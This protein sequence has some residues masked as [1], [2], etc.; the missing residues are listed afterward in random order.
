MSKIK[1]GKGFVLIFTITVLSLVTILT[2]QLLRMVNVGS[3]FDRTM[4]N[5][6]RAEM[7]ALGGIS[8]AISQ[9]TV[10]KKKP[11]KNSKKETKDKKKP[12]GKKDKAFTAYLQNLIPNLNRWQ[13][14]ELDEEIDGIDGE[15]KI[16]I[17]SEDGKININEAFD[18][19]KQEFKPIYKKFLENLKFKGAVGGKGGKKGSSLF[20]K[21]LVKFLKKRSRK[22]DDISE[23][24]EGLGKKLSQLFYEPPKRNDKPKK[25]VPNTALPIQ[26]IF[27]I[28][29]D[30]DKLEGLLLS[31]SLCGMLGFKR[32][33]A[34]DAELRKEVFK[35]VI[36]NFSPE[37]D[38]NTD[39]YWKMLKPLYLPKNITNL[40]KLK[41]FSSKFEPR[42]YSV[43]SSGKVGKVEQRVLAVIKKVKITEPAKS[44]K[45]K[46]KEDKKADKAPQPVEGFKIVR[47]YWI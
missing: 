11:E 47:L 21:E 41:I 42:T 25:A 43:L 8:L 34:H 10:E 20:L 9:L 24:Q 3:K 32:P 15:L 12:G 38:Q 40:T 28:W 35:K 7:L 39:K 18:F 23:L 26:D 44:T 29:K 27:T 17:S 16:C 2:H 19:K 13:V 5:R 22:I 45:D 36:K 6:E 1:R 14:F 33:S 37:T 30:D 31:D 4:V 46:K